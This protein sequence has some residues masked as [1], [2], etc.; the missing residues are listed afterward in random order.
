MLELIDRDG[1]G[2]GEER[3]AALRRVAET[4]LAGS[5]R[6]GRELADGYLPWVAPRLGTPSWLAKWWP[7]ASLPA[8]V[9]LGMLVALVGDPAWLRGL[10]KKRR[11][12]RDL[13]RLV[14]VWTS[15]V[16]APVLRA[17]LAAADGAGGY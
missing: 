6:G 4:L 7:T 5:L 17:Y 15:H 2:E 9:A 14:R 10:S 12:P 1:V 13:T 16:S 3:S 8:R 11:D